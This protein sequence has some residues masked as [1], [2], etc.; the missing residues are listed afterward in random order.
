MGK[1]GEHVE[2]EPI[3]G[4]LVMNPP[5]GSSGRESLWLCAVIGCTPI[6]PVYSAL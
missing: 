3:M 6:K 2:S 4:D 5:M 1:P